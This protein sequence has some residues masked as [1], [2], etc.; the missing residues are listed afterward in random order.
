MDTI[1]QFLQDAI[2]WRFRPHLLFMASVTDHTSPFGAFLKEHIAFVG[3]RING[4]LAEH[5]HG[6]LEMTDG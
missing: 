5:F 2:K 3:G 4:E 6:N 1:S